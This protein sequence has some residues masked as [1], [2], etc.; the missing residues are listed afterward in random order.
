MKCHL[1]SGL[2]YDS[3]LFRH[4]Y[5]GL[6][7][8]LPSKL[9]ALDYFLSGF[10]IMFILVNALLLGAAVYVWA[11][12]RILGRFQNR[13]GPNRWGPFGLFQPIADLVKLIT[14]EDLIPR[15]ADRI[16][17]TLVPIIM[18]SPV[19]L[20][21][22]VV[23]FAKNT[24]LADLSIGILFIIAISSV[25]TLAIFMGGWSSGNR[26][27]MFGAMR[28]V[29]MLIS[30][31]IPVVLS[32]VGVV[33]ITGSMRMT[34]VVSAQTIPFLLV[35]PL[36]ILVFMLGI[37][38][39]LNRTPFD[40]VEAESELTAGFHTEYSGMKFMLIQTGEFGGVLAASAVMATLF[41][42][43]WSG[44][45][46]SGQLGAL[47]FLLKIL[48]F[49]FLFIWVRAT[50]PRLRVDQI[51]ALAWKFLFPLSLI[52]L[53]ATTIQVYFLRDDVTGALS[54]AD[55]GIMTGINMALA[56]VAIAFFASAIKEKVRP[57]ARTLA[58]DITS[59]RR[60][61]RPGGLSG[62]SATSVVSAESAG[63]EK[64]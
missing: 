58:P 11:E 4:I 14:K 40:L 17:F 42:G 7:E 60:G 56:V 35:Q 6:G 64:G 32:L 53:F 50:F 22:A 8:V 44:P 41:L 18:V 47:W 3:V 29:A 51:M 12:R 36:G 30:Y 26:Y 13:L 43:G 25:S 5:N 1:D 19:I 62:A 9:C 10:I 33:L 38:A 54:R 57:P 23:P 55:L 24:A 52:N 31:E 27:A 15:G 61:G 48:F 28:G 45:F 37:S 46:L 39:E 59:I 2:L 63:I 34:D 49:V 20:M 16:A 21:L